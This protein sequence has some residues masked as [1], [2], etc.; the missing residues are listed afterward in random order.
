MTDNK[1][2]CI[3]TATDITWSDIEL[4]SG[5]SKLQKAIHESV[6]KVPK[7]QW[8]ESFEIVDRHFSTWDNRVDPQSNGDLQYAPVLFAWF[9]KFHLNIN[10]TTPLKIMR[11]IYLHF[12]Q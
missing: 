10:Y 8:D 2:K 12:K 9:A 11:A 4:S 5:I 3:P 6:G 7:H 1:V